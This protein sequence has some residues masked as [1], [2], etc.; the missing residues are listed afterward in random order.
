MN[1]SKN[2]PLKQYNTFG[3]EARAKYLAR[4]KT[5]DD[6]KDLLQMKEFQ[7]EKRFILGGGSNVLFTQDYDGLV[8]LINIEGLRLFESNPDYAIMKAAAGENWHSF[9]DT[10]TK[11]KYYGLEN[12]ALIPGKIG[13]APVQNIG[14]YAVEQ[15][16]FFYRLEG[17]NI[18][19]GELE[20]LSYEDCKFAYRDS[21]FKNELK[22]KFI[23]T[24]VYYKLQREWLPNLNYKE[25]EIEWNKFGFG[26]VERDSTYLF[27]TVV[28]VRKSKLPDPKELGNAGSFFK[29]PIVSIEKMDAL[30][31][32]YSELPYYPISADLAKIPAAW[33]IE[34]NGWKGRREGNAGV[35]EKHSLILVAY[36]GASGLEVFN[37]SEKIIKSVVE[38]FGIRLE[39]E[40]IVL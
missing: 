22:D 30:K 8:V 12:L 34:Q 40:V 37:L 9:V 17:I 5:I 10:C 16:D 27:N 20:E 23:I 14:A 32:V 6:L 26:F 11:N 7:E 25:L 2:I 15:K 35:S 28:R 19:T 4:I 21:I 1:L 3:V 39:R 13:A 36:E 29:N 18:E 24:H 33:L 31:T 38:K